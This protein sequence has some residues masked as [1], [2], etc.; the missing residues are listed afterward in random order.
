M[1]YNVLMWTLNPAHS[2]ILMG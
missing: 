2:P 1:I